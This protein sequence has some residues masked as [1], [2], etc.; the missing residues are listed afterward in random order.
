ML[1]LIKILN[2]GTITLEF[3]ELGALT[4][5][6]S[7]T[8]AYH[9]YTHKTVY[10]YVYNL[11]LYCHC[12]YDHVHLKK[13]AKADPP[14]SQVLLMELNKCIEEKGAKTVKLKYV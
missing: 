5:Q 8:Y 12:Q 9:P 13:K 1:S 10:I 2:A 11:I 4:A 14:F 3:K 7:H 6:W